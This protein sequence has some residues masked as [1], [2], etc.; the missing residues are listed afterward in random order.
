M[1]YMHNVVTLSTNSKHTKMGGG[2][3]RT[4]RYSSV[5][6]PLQKNTLETH[7]SQGIL[8]YISPKFFAKMDE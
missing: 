1:F 4:R 7:C 3:R 2:I 6:T 8:L 5:H